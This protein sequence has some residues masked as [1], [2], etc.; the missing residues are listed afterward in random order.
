MN[1]ATHS[2]SEA[3]AF[4]RSCGRALCAVCIQNQ[5]GVPYCEA[6][7]AKDEGAQAAFEAGARWRRE[8][9]ESDS[10]AATLTVSSS[11]GHAPSRMRPAVRH[12]DPPSPF[13]ALILGLIPGVG[14]VYNGHYAKAVFHVVVFGGIVT[15]IGAGTVRGLEPLFVMLAI[16]FFLYM[17]IEAYRT[18]RA[19]K[20]GEQVDEFSGL[21]SLVF[22]DSH[23][24]AFGITLIGLGI[25]FLLQSLGYW[26]IQNFL[27]YWPLSLIGL[28]IY[29]LYR[30]LSGPPWQEAEVPRRNFEHISRRPNVDLGEDAGMP[31]DRGVTADWDDSVGESEPPEEV[32]RTNL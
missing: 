6:C 32:R 9:P 2:E 3:A 13:L 23:S 5:Q 4:C 7:R 22:A 30:R 1:C 25:V 17:P 16:M 19:V 24:P 15:L 26:R 21:L 10:A 11:T 12:A 29:M 8:N 18:A 31:A 14:A 27:P 20:R 28:G